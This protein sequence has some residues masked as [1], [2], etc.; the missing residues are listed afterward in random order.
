[1]FTAYTLFSLAEYMVV[2]VNCLFYFL[3]VWESKGCFVEISVN[4]NSML[5]LETT[6]TMVNKKSGKCG[7]RHR[8]NI[9]T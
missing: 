5:E 1:M 2:G 7:V 6:N 8:N 9:K 4:N 3:L